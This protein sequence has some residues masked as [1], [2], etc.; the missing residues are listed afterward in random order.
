MNRFT[1]F[2]VVALF[3][4][5]LTACDG[6]EQ[7]TNSTT[8]GAVPALQATPQVPSLTPAEELTR[9]I[10]WGQA[11]QPEI[12]Q[13]QAELQQTFTSKNAATITEAGKVFENKFVQIERELIALETKDSAVNQLKMKM[14]GTM[15]LSKD[16][17]SHAVQLAANPNR[18][19]E[20]NPQIQEKKQVLLKLTQEVQQVTLELLQKFGLNQTQK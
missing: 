19:A 14:L 3:S 16:L 7:T 5:F 6:A 12:A 17:I 18:V 15:M 2:S 8:T 20:I 13:L 9:L 1:K 4:V 11:K 10:S